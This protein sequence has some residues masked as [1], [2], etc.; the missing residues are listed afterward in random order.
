MEIGVMEI[1]MVKV[2]FSLTMEAI[3]VDSLKMVQNQVKDLYILKMG[4]NSTEIGN[5]ILHL[6]K[7]S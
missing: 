3:I 5:L 4:P 7:V 2:N 1:K 6:E